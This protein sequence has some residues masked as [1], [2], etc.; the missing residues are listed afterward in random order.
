MSE[1]SLPTL[2]DAKADSSLSSL[3]LFSGPALVQWKFVQLHV[4]SLE[5]GFAISSFIHSVLQG[6]GSSLTA[7]AKL[8]TCKLY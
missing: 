1:P 7:R 8:D 3:L 6:H 5:Q 4:V 2:S